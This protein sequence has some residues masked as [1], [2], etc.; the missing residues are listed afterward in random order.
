MLPASVD[1]LV[2]GGGTSGCVIAGRLAERGDESILVVEAGPDYGRLAAGRWPE[3]LVDAAMLAVGAYDWGYL[4][5]V[6]RHRGELRFDRAKVIGGCSSH[7]GCAAIWG[8]RLDY[9]AWAHAGN[10]GWATDDLAPL[11]REANARM[12]VRTPPRSEMTPYQA[13]VHDAL[14]AWGVPATDDLNDLDEDQGV[15]PS[16]VNI[17]AGVRFN[18]AFAY[19]DPVRDRAG[20]TIVGDVL[21]DRL[22]VESGR[23]VGAELVADGDRV[24]VRAARTIVAAGTYNSP[25]ILERSGI[26][27]PAVL[28]PLGIQVVHDLRGVGKNLHDHPA[29]DF[30][31]AGTPELTGQMQARAAAGFCPEEQVIA[32]VRSPVASEAFD[33]HV[34]PVGGPDWEGRGGYFYELPVACMTPRSRGWCHVGSAD[35]A[36]LP[37]IDHAFLSDPEGHDRAVLRAGLEIAREL[38]ALEP[39]HSLIGDEVFAPPERLEDAWVHYFHPVGTCKMGP[40]SDPDAVVDPRGRI[41]GLEGGYVADCAVI[42]TIPRANTNIPAVVVGERVVSWL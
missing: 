42:P 15:A 12:R 37:R 1:T 28:E 2:V 21:A 22:L 16:P 39:L 11:F 38:V 9:D 23:I 17:D 20:L 34:Y 40:A 8:H 33:L 4:S 35:P 32:K 5:G 3:P 25:G 19:L 36:A 27:D 10:E 7:N 41:H 13:A 26:G 31:F 30:F 24:R 6:V 29:I 14:A 18:T